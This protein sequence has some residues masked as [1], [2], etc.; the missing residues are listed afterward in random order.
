MN[1]KTTAEQKV[2]TEEE[3]E[4]ISGGIGGQNVYYCVEGYSKVYNGP[5]KLYASTYSD[6]ERICYKLKLN[7]D[8]IKEVYDAH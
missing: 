8:C 2:L 1:E 4:L 3:L 6:A 5:V 7:T